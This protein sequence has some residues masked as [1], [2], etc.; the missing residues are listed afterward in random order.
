M[1]ISKIPKNKP[2][3][4]KDLEDLID[5]VNAHSNMTGKGGISVTNTTRGTSIVGMQ[6]VFKKFKVRRAIT[7]QAASARTFIS[8]NLY[9][10]KGVE[11]TEG[12]EFGVNVHCSIA[13]DT[14]LNAAI[15]RLENNDDIFVAKMPYSSAGSIVQRWWC[16]SIFQASEDCDNEGEYDIITA[17]TANYNLTAA[18]DVIVGGAGNETFTVDVPAPGGA[19]AGKVFWVKNVG[20]GV[21]T[22]DADV[23]GSSTIDG[24]ATQPINKGD[25]LK[26]ISDGSQWWSV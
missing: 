1:R 6:S 18:D 16:V 23:D 4:G 25:T 2:V 15:P 17:A 9:N 10:N 7:T 11:V 19:L 8:A 13:G 12:A 21:V 5:K 14:N 22:A 3:I 26:I 20:T 24:D